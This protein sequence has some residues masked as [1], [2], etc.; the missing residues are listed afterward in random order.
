MIQKNPSVI[1]GKNAINA[2]GFGLKET[3]RE[4]PRSENGL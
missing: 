1:M 4:E 2:A 3:P